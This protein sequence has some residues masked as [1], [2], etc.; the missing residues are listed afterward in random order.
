[1]GALCEKL[2]SVELRI[3]TAPRHLDGIINTSGQTLRQLVHQLDIPYYTTDDINNCS[4]LAEFV[5]P[6]T[7]G[8]ALGAAWIFESST[9]QLFSG[10]LLDFMG[11]HLPQYRGGAHY[12]WQILRG[13][14]IGA[15]NLQII[16]GG[17]ATFH[18]GEIIKHHTYFFPPSARIP[19]DY[20][21]AAISHELVFLLEFFEEIAQQKEFTIQPLQEDFNSYYPFLYTRQHGYIDWRWHTDE[22]ERFICA[23]DDPYDGASTFLG[24]QR[25]FLKSCHAEYGEGHFHPF[26]VGLIYRK[27]DKTYF[28][29]TREGSLIIHSLKDESGQPMAA[30]VGQRFYTPQT[31][32]DEAMQFQA[33]YDAKGLKK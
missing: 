10:K 31:V 22:I 3:F 6:S 1:M 9:A 12:S 15:C 16:H 33:I 32:L 25:M 8:L 18:K 4:E 11:I 13:D 20:F 5:T 14:K 30:Q 19:Q 29:A 26:Q 2:R 23:F 28:V 17:E 24:G 27:A 7:L 21:D